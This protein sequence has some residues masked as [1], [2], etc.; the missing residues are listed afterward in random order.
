MKRYVPPS[1]VYFVQ[2]CMMSMEQVTT[3]D[4]NEEI[5]AIKSII[6]FY[7]KQFK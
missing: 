4:V 3:I 1:T 6:E 5:V 2:Y 7:Y